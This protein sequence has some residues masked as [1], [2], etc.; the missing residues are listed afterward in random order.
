ML[1][2]A[3]VTPSS[4]GSPRA[5]LAAGCH[6]CRIGLVELE[7]ID[8]LA[9]QHVGIAAAEH[10]HPPHQLADDDLDVLVVDAHTL[11]AI[12]LLNLVQEVHLGGLATLNAQ[13][14]ARVLRALGQLRADL[15]AIALIDPQ[16]GRSRDVG[17]PLFHVLAADDRLVAALIVRVDV[18][19]AIE[20]AR[21]SA[22]SR[23]GL[24]ALDAIGVEALHAIVTLD[25]H[26]V[27]GLNQVRLAPEAAVGHLQ[28]AHI[29]VPV[30][31][32]DAADFR[33][34]GLA[35][36]R[37]GLEEFLDAAGPA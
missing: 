28:L 34:H 10:T 5:R 15:D 12:D 36:G 24:R 25:Q 19:V 37:A 6:H 32:H 29:I 18:D 35:L 21:I 16:A 27:A 4:T 3:F 17:H 33:D 2:D 30:H 1:S 20:R 14:L 7:A 22:G 9:D 8:E 31:V 26:L 23:S 11:G 13:H